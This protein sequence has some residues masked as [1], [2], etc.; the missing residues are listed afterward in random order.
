MNRPYFT[1][2]KSTKRSEITSVL[3]PGS[4]KMLF[5]S[6][7]TASCEPAA[8]PERPKIKTQGW[9]VTLADVRAIEGEH[10][11]LSEHAGQVLAEVAGNDTERLR[12]AE[13]IFRSLVE[14]DNRGRLLRRP[15]R[16]GEISEIAGCDP[17][18]ISEIV[19]GFRGSGRTFLTPYQPERLE[20]NTEIDVSHEALIWRWDQISGTS[21]KSGWLSDEIRDGQRYRT[22]V[23][24]LFPGPLPARQTRRW[25]DWWYE[26]PRTSAW[27]SRY[28]GRYGE[29]ATML[30]SSRTRARRRWLGAG[31]LIVLLFVSTDIVW[32][33]W[34]ARVAAEHDV[35][36]LRKA[37]VEL[38]ATTLNTLL[39]ERNVGS[40]VLSLTV[41]VDLRLASGG[42]DGNIA[43]WPEEGT[44]ELVIL[45][46]GTPVLSLAV[47]ADG[48]LASG[49]ED[50]KIKLWPK[51]GTGEPSVLLH[52]SPVLSLAVL[53]DGW[54]ASGGEDGSIRLW[55]KNGMGKPLVLLHGGP[56]LSLAVLADGR[57]ASGGEDGNIKLWPKNGR[58]PP[59][60]LPQRS[61]VHVP[62]STAGRAAGLR[63]QR[64]QD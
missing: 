21:A 59:V 40:P 20:V 25:T 58:D 24:T 39:G 43:V 62:G 18:I 9:T 35:A 12:A 5:P 38:T 54:L 33:N 57:L 23:G 52:G 32:L 10:G 8:T 55:P 29:V 36:K 30:I 64:R 1:A 6:S 53:G 37:V 3:Q 46:H 11:A 50:G 2:A 31:L 48:R 4:K 7:N 13:W 56:V 26:R 17:S 14:L 22:L 41:L 15:R 61:P 42:E 44:R 16:I 34:R 60:V 45:A 47:L 19:E 51:N 63:R 28:G 49:G 27:A